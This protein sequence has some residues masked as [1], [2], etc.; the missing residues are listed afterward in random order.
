VLHPAEQKPDLPP[1]LFRRFVA[2]PGACHDFPPNQPVRE[3]YGM[4]TTNGL[5]TIHAGR[6]A[7]NNPGKPA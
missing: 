2:Y 7:R 5:G 1:G 6:L 4:M 3:R